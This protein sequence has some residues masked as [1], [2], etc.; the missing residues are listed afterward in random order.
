MK[1]IPHCLTPGKHIF[2]IRS[3]FGFGTAVAAL[4]QLVLYLQYTIPRL[5][6]KLFRGV[7]AISE[8]DWSFAPIL[9]SSKRFST[10]TGSDLHIVLPIFHPGQ[11]Q[12][13]RFRVYRMLLN[14]LF[15]L[16]FALRPFLKNLRCNI[17]V[18]RWLIKQKARSHL[19]KTAS[20]FI[21]LLPFVG[22]WFQVLFHPPVRSTFH[23]SLTVLVHYRSL[24]SIQP[25][26]MVLADSR[27]IPRAP[28][29]SGYFKEFQ[30]FHLPDFHRLWLTFPSHSINSKICN[31]LVYCKF[32]LKSH[33]TCDTTIAVY[34][35]SQG[36]GCFHFARRYFGNHYCFIFQKVLRCFSSLRQLTLPIYS[37]K[38][39]QILLWIG[40]PIRRS[41]GQRLLP[42]IRGFSQVATSFIAYQCQGIHH[43][44][45]VTFSKNPILIQVVSP[46]KSGEVH[47]YNLFIYYGSLK[48]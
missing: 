1:L 21:R 29:Y 37:A 32:T 4:A 47:Q 8:F 39:I 42:S 16:A 10:H 2:V 27:R 17:R 30:N 44:P 14:A 36:L 7:R 23:L 9:N 33:N 19:N 38:Y 24:I 6:L 25:Y 41:T 26:Q 5:A 31:S 18:T 11:E 20:C 43:M 15:G 13:T 46:D 45:F 40:C 35:I 12:I 34:Y 28:R 48:Y 3:L 22:I